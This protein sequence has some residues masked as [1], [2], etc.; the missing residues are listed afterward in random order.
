[1][2]KITHRP[3]WGFWEV[4]KVVSPTRTV[5]IGIFNSEA[6]AE[7]YAKQHKG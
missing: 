1:M 7:A 3:H 5:S 2:I 6:K 4:L